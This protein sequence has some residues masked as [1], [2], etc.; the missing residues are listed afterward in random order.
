MGVYL[1]YAPPDP[2]RPIEPS[3]LPS[4]VP[5][6]LGAIWRMPPA[7]DMRPGAWLWWFWL[8]FIHD[9][10]TIKTGKC[11]QLMILWSI[12]QD[13]KI[14]C[15]GLDIRI[16]EPFRSISDA[17]VK[18]TKHILEG[19]TAA[20]YFDGERM[21]DDFILQ[22]GK[23]ALDPPARLLDAPG[24]KPTSF[25]QDGED[26][27]TTISTPEISFEFR[28]RQADKHPCIGPT[29]SKT[30]FPANLA[31]VEGTRLERMDLSG[32]EFVGQ[33]ERSQE[34]TGEGSTKAGNARKTD[35]PQKS[36]DCTKTDGPQKAS[37]LRKRKIFGTAYFQ[38]ILM[39]APPPQWYWG[40]YH[41]KDGSMATY[42]QTYVGAAM[43]KDNLNLSGLPLG[44]P[45]FTPT[46][47]ILIYHA[48]SK[49]VFEGHALEVKAEKIEK[50]NSASDNIGSPGGKHRASL[51]IH[52]LGGGGPGFKFS[53]R[54][55]AYS[56][57]CW[58]FE[59]NIGALPVCST[60]K[61]NEYPAVL[62]ELVITPDKG[63]AIRLKM[64]W[65]N[66]ENAWGFLV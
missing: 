48:P 39:A 2:A 54:A 28:A 42:M 66:M 19:A 11:R 55:V 20:W 53:G 40:L 63:P 27:I 6:I 16:D 41:F 10:E 36:G 57:A 1:T 9:D 5:E 23:M 46:R 37:V 35:G 59:K 22:T 14:K 65:G 4:K 50:M 18:N 17:N 33:R 61:Y 8:F 52:H 44:G 30:V 24:K 43:L 7:E 38:K 32:F 49:K 15:N 51:Y 3:G 12:K 62:E 26:F 58:S 60:F 29:H 47:D 56:H 21:D 34:K 45:A 25:R 64:G 31:L 13:P